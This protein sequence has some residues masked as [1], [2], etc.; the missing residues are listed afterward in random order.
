[1]KRLFFFS[2]L[3]SFMLFM[4]ASAQTSFLKYY[5]GSGNEDVS[6][7][8]VTKKDDSYFAIGN[9]GNRILIVEFD[10]S[11]QEISNRTI[12]VIDENKTPVC[13]SACIDY[14]GKL[15]ICGYRGLI[16]T[17]STYEAFVL[18]FDYANDTVLW[19][20][21]I[22]A[23]GSEGSAFNKVGHLYHQY[24]A[25]VCGYTSEPEKN[26]EATWWALDPVTGFLDQYDKLNLSPG[27]EEFITF[28]PVK[29]VSSKQILAGSFDYSDNGDSILRPVS[30][31]YGPVMLQDKRGYL[32]N[33]STTARLY[34]NDVSSDFSRHIT[35]VCSGDGSGSEVNKDLYYY[36]YKGSESQD[37]L[38]MKKIEFTNTDHDG[39]LLGVRVNPYFEEPRSVIYGNKNDPLSENQLGNAFLISLFPKDELSWAKS[40]PF[41][42]PADGRGVDAMML[43]GENTLVVG[44][45]FDESS[46]YWKGAIL[47]VDVATGSLPGCET[48]EEVELLDEP[49]VKII[50]FVDKS[51]RSDHISSGKIKIGETAIASSEECSG[52][53]RE[54]IQKIKDELFSESEKHLF[55]YPN[56]SSTHIHLQLPSTPT[57]IAIFNLLGEKVKE[58]KVS[59]PAGQAGGGEI[60]MDVSELPAGLY[61]VRTEEAIVGKFVKE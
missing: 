27:N 17:L 38:S 29:S 46:G 2:A 7:S 37:I 43:D 4:D 10:E 54:D 18:A 51:P 34:L 57:T 50:M 1:M 9:E 24:K 41:T 20:R 6:F 47:S 39:K 33:T 5:A 16:G 55:V 44:R 21:V 22:E 12:K 53:I 35:V 30:C 36:T 14:Y 26:Q 48:V 32:R 61:F 49:K 52:F 58:E 42:C 28:A 15:D 56:P 23:T 8:S 45:A 31:R 59:L 11:G 40:Y 3:T 60:T 25:A 19:L 13:R